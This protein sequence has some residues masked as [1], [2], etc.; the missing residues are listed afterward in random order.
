LAAKGET[1]SN[2]VYKMVVPEP[3]LEAPGLVEENKF[4]LAESFRDI[5]H[6]NIGNLNF[7]LDKRGSG[8]SMKI[9][10]C[11]VFFLAEPQPEN[12]LILSVKTGTVEKKAEWN[13]VYSAPDMWELWVDET[14]RF[15]FLTPDIAPPK[16]CI[17]VD[18]DFTSG[19]VIGNFNIIPAREGPEVY[20]LQNIEITFFI[21][22]L[23]NSND[24]VLHAA[25]A[26]IDGKG[27]CFAGNSGRGKSTL[28]KALRAE[29]GCTI[30]GEDNLILRWL[31][32]QF[33]I[34]GTPWHTNPEMCSPLG[35]PLSK[36][37]FLDR[38]AEQGIHHCS[39]VEGTSRLLQSAF[40][41]YYRKEK[42]AGLVNRI[43]ML[44]EQV[45]FFLYHYKMGTDP[46]D[47]IRSNLG[48]EKL[49]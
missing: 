8:I 33:W 41:P 20:P 23:A 32:G 48:E 10:D 42:V 9:P 31:N 11:H 14:G 45:P 19:E 37:F 13:P 22:W 4:S 49:V 35:A 17:T 5:I 40:I 44:A 6:F 25:G 36:F 1:L 7:S 43:G 47:T 26:L 27:Y 28:A 39:P 30:L 38:Q 21:N 3:V 34:F 12:R 18:R 29:P 2:G 46:W 16:R 15:V 24:L